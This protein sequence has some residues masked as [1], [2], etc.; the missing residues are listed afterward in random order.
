MQAMRQLLSQHMNRTRQ[1]GWIH[2]QGENHEVRYLETG[3]DKGGDIP[4]PPAFS[5]ALCRGGGKGR[6]QTCW[7]TLPGRE[8]SLC[9]LNLEKKSE[10]YD[11]IVNRLIDFYREKKKNE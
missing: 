10:S 5:I 3:N 11:T 6:G 1:S 8:G 4:V 2:F 9:A 7:G